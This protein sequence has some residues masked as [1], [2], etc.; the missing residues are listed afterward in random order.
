VQRAA[1]SPDAAAG[2]RSLGSL[3]ALFLRHTRTLAT[4]YALLAALDARRAAISLAWLLSAGLVVAVLIVTAWL[5]LVTGAIVW[6]L[7]SGAS[8]SAAL[9]VAALL[10]IVGA[11]ALALWMRGFFKA[12]PFAATLRQLQGE[13]PSAGANRDG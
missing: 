11:V 13:P 4:D 12:L 10:N 7:G 2:G 1:A 8:W 5:A 3:A 9:G 6:L